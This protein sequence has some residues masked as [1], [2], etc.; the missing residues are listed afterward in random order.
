MRLSCKFC[1]GRAEG[2]GERPVSMTGVTRKNPH[3]RKYQVS[4]CYPWADHI[5]GRKPNVQRM[6]MVAQEGQVSRS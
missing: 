6:C 4:V 1:L 3:W 2:L 5:Y